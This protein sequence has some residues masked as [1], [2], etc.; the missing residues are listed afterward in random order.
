ME[1][2]LKDLEEFF[3]SSCDT[4]FDR[5]TF[6]S[7]DKIIPSQIILKI[8]VREYFILIYVYVTRVTYECFKISLAIPDKHILAIPV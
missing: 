7:K 2:S 4:R 6:L 8:R 5:P 3:A 1:E